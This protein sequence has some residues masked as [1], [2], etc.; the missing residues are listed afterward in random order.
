MKEYSLEEVIVIYDNHL[1]GWN[2]YEY[3]NEA[4]RL[5]DLQFRNWLQEL[6]VRRRT[7]KTY[8][9]AMKKINPKSETEII[10]SLIAENEALR[11]VIE[12]LKGE[13]K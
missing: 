8:A 6:R 9:S 10:E 4:Q 7:C 12:R 13:K 5:E 11:A 2:G 1:L 3:P